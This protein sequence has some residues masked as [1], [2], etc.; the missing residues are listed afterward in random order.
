LRLDAHQGVIFDIEYNA[1]GNYMFS[2]SDDRSIN[3]YK[4]EFTS[5]QSESIQGS[6][7]TRFYGH[8]AR[9]W[10]SLSFVDERTDTL[11]LCSIGEDLRC[12]LWSVTDRQLI[13]RFGSMKK[14]SKNIWCICFNSS[15]QHIITGWGDGG[16]RRFD[17]RSHLCNKSP[18]LDIN[19][20]EMNVAAAA[21]ATTTTTTVA[22][23]A[24]ARDESKFTID[25]AATSGGNAD[26]DSIEWDLSYECEKDFIRNIVLLNNRV[27]CCTNLG[28]LYLIK[29]ESGN[30]SSSIGKNQ[31]LL[32]KSVLLTNY[33]VMAKV[34]IGNEW[35]LAIGTLKGFIYLLRIR[36]ENEPPLAGVGNVGGGGGGGGDDETNKTEQI[37]ID[38]LNCMSVEESL[39]DAADC[40][41]TK[42]VSQTGSSKICSLDWHEYTTRNSNGDYD[43]NDKD[44]QTRRYF[45]LACFS[46]MNGLMHL[47][48][49]DP[50]KN[51]L[52]LIAR[53]YLPVCK[54]RWLSSYAIIATQRLLLE[55]DSDE[56]DSSRLSAAGGRLANS[57]FSL[58]QNQNEL[59]YLAC[60]DKCG[61]MH[62]YEIEVNKQ[63]VDTTSVELDSCG[64]QQQIASLSLL[65]PKESLKNLTK[66]NSSISAIYSLS[67]LD[68]SSSSGSQ[69]N[70]LSCFIVCCCKDGYY[71]VY[72]FNNFR[73]SDEEEL[74]YGGQNENDD[75]TNEEEE[76]EKEE[77]A[78]KKAKLEKSANP[79]VSSMLRLVNKY[80][81]STSID[82]IESFIFY[83]D[84]T[85]N[86]LISFK[87]VV[88]NETPPLEIADVHEMLALA[89]CFYGSK[90][91]LWSFRLNRALAEISCGGAN[92]SWDFN[93]ASLSSDNVLFRLVYIKNKCICENHRQ[94]ALD[95]LR[96]L[97]AKR[98]HFS[99]LFHGNLI[100]KCKYFHRPSFLFTGGEDTQLIISRLNI[101]DKTT[102]ICHQQHLQ[103]HD[104]T[105]KCVNYCSIN[106]FDYLLVSAGGKVCVNL[107]KI[108]FSESNN[109]KLSHLIDL[110]R[111][112]KGRSSNN[113]KPWLYV[114]L[115][116]NPDIRFM[117]VVVFRQENRADQFSICFACSDG[118]IR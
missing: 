57:S 111:L 41:L 28:C 56:E 18:T 88:N 106:Q 84:S 92:R 66:Q 108:S 25:E 33:N 40:C 86:K 45:L 24:V 58:Q 101:N 72:E 104:S 8:E 22:E 109:M 37:K 39:A 85:L 51:Q 43:D 78:N 99:H 114:D 105:V 13:H 116:A 94:L 81:I 62:L 59:I 10:K 53:L 96:P 32:F 5:S 42:S 26:G 44:K 7:Y 83:N 34:K 14:S 80:Q 90:F 61:S 115:E 82:I 20:Q 70:K 118:A 36:L 69:S 89:L 73:F 16:L 71:R 76:E 93:F 46:F 52:N 103:G 27:I 110:K 75:Y 35:C 97:I 113:L 3:I 9:V 19:S 68:A 67:M 48:E 60:G 64:E 31:K 38:C 54:H 98:N 87:S 100:N 63:L 2:V 17:L 12:C 79:N 47:Y 102:P 112:K 117:D 77:K 74:I 6:L 30:S 107:W 91:L 55:S 65:R 29:I 49:M 95:E 11:Y 15:S 21:V 23:A 50:L 4:L 1:S